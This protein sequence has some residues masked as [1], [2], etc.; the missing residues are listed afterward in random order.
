[1]VY[2][3]ETQKAISFYQKTFSQSAQSHR[4][5]PEVSAPG[6]HRAK[7]L[8]VTAE[9]LRGDH[10][11]ISSGI[12]LIFRCKSMIANAALDIT[13]NVTNQEEVLLINH[14][15][16]IAPSNELIPGIYELT[17]EIP[18]F[19]F[20]EGDYTLDVWMGLSGTECVGKK[21]DDAISFFVE[22]DKVDETLKKLPGALRPQIT[23]QSQLLTYAEAG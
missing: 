20:N 11:S 5:W 1:M 3:D 2:S 4:E 14:G 16:L 18:P 8:S 10:I 15:R 17:A 19:L 9:P 13:Y 7:L 22:S 12:K 21:V 23:Y 6:D